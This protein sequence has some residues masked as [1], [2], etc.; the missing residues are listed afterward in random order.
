MRVLFGRSLLLNL[1]TDQSGERV[2]QALEDF[3]TETINHRPLRYII[4][5]SIPRHQV[6]SE[7]SPT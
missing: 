4:R 7:S 5:F 2:R 3:L 1:H 6:T